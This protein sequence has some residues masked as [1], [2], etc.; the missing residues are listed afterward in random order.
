MRELLRSSYTLNI[1]GCYTPPPA[2]E[3]FWREYM[4]LERIEAGAEKRAPTPM[5]LAKTALWLCKNATNEN[6][7][8]AN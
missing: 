2:N 4:E 8:R 3:E 6:N 1:Y 5:E 7:L